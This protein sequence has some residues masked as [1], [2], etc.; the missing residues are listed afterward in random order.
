MRERPSRLLDKKVGLALGGGAARGLAHIGVLEVLEKEGIP[1][2]MIAGTSAGAAVGALYAQGRNTGAIKALALDLNWKRLASLVD[3][4]LP[5]TGF[6][7][8]KKIKEQLKSIIGGDI[9][10]SD[11][12]IPFACVATDIKT[13]EEIVIS[14]GSVLDGV[15]ASISIPAIFT[16]IKRE[17]RYLVDGG[18]VNPVPVSVVKKQ[19]ADFI[20]AVNVTADAVNRTNLGKKAKEPT[21]F[22]VIMQSLYISTHSLV[23]SSLEGA[24]IVIEPNLAD[25]PYGDF[26]RAKEGILRGALAAQGIIPEIK[27]QLNI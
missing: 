7:Q 21:I 24:D 5:R 14:Q 16:L 18:L 23:K 12:K 10:F 27:R 3:L 11:L 22:N 6:I 17:G 8:G 20:I 4:A 13:G 25:I 15:R 1:I 2:D 9:K 19:G 26:Q